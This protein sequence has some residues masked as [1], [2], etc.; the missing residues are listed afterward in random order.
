MLEHAADPQAILS[1]T[2][3][4]LRTGGWCYFS[5]PNRFSLGPEPS[6]R[7]WGVGF[8]PR[9][10]ASRYVRLV[11]G[12]P[13]RNIRALSFFELRRMVLRAG[14]Q[15]WS[16]FPPRLAECELRTLSGLRRRLA[17]LYNLLQEVPVF[18]HLLL[19]VG[20]FLQVVGRK[21]A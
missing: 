17:R 14:L 11:R 6:V 15:T 2:V 21:H 8:A 4:T 13:Y 1:E 18:R 19:A 16:M 20:P 12:I 9:S 7:V 10:L 3:R 5:T